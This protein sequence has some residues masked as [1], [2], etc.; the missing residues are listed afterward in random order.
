MLQNFGNLDQTSGEKPDQQRGDGNK[1]DGAQADKAIG[2]GGDI[3]NRGELVHQGDDPD[4][5][6]SQPDPP[7]LV[8]GKEVPLAEQ[9]DKQKEQR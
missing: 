7:S 3:K 4:R 6:K 1:K 9:F 5:Q 2:L 8:K